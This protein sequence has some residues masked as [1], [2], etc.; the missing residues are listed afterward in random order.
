MHHN[1]K[2]HQRSS[3]KSPIFVPKTHGKLVRALWLTN[4]VMVTL[5]VLN[6]RL[7]FVL[8]HLVTH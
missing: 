8:Q 5:S 7:V 2:L 6:A 4:P 3:L 1:Q